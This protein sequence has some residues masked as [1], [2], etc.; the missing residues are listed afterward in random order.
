MKAKQTY[1]WEA[2]GYTFEMYEFSPIH[3]NWCMWTDNGEGYEVGGEIE[4]GYEKDGTGYVND[5]D[6]AF[7]LPKEIKTWLRLKNIIVDF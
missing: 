7:D 1:T 5:F 6:G 2:N 3:Y 4:L